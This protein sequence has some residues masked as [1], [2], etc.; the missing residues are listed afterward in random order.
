MRF[1]IVVFP[2][3]NCDHDTHHVLGRILGQ[4]TVELWH[5]DADLKASDAIIVPGGFSFGDYLRCGAIAKFSP[6][7]ESVC[8]FA[9][10][11]G[12]VLGICNGFQILQEAGLLPGALLRNKGLKF[13]CE[14][15]SCRVERSDTIFT[16]ACS[17]GQV[18]R[19]PI[20]HYD[21]NFYASPQEFE[22]LEENRQI[23]FRY[24]NPDGELAPSA[25]PNGSMGAVAGI[26]NP[27]GNV[28]ALMPH[29]ERAAEDELGC[30]D[31]RVILES[32]VR[33]LSARRTALPA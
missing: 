7:M 15:V 33:S 27:R 16:S 4:E 10:A 1:G 22:R 24:C 19:I 21:G 3:S 5:G 20:A 8:R 28:M 30:S 18:I 12:P 32:L 25:N 13:V 2:G 11:G 17:A 6:V 14:H 23:L 29:P 26:V 31:G 9:D